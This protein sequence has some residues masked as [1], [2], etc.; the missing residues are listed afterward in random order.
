MKVVYCPYCKSQTIAKKDFGIGSFILLTLL[1]GGFWL[2]IGPIYHFGFQTPKCKVCNNYI[3][4]KKNGQLKYWI[5]CTIALVM[6]IYVIK[7]NPTTSIVLAMGMTSIVAG[8]FIGNEY[9]KNVKSKARIKVQEDAQA[10]ELELITN[11]QPYVDKYLNS[12]VMNWGD[13]PQDS[14]IKDNDIDALALLINRDSPLVVNSNIVKLAIEK[15]LATKKQLMFDNAFSRLLLDKQLSP[16]THNVSYIYQSAF[17]KNFKYLDFLTKFMANNNVAVSTEDL[18]FIITEIYAQ[19]STKRHA[20]NIEHAMNLG[21]SFDRNL[22]I[23]DIDCL[24]GIVFEQVLAKLFDR[25]GYMV[26]TTKASGD[27]GADLLL[28]KNGNKTVVQAKRYTNN[29]DNTPVQEVVAAKVHYGYHEAMVV[30]NRYFTKGAIELAASNH[31]QLID[32]DILT[33]YLNSYP[34]TI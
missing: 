18:K 13:W 19:E 3:A 22:T 21:K 2:L 12:F 23:N 14:P 9:F 7:E 30:T 10:A 24:D 32:R 29:L 16:T 15:Q 1:T 31:V 27:Q 4:D 33:N 20:A 28:E 34:I 5:I 8:I 6:I 17:G 11:I 26:R 25:M